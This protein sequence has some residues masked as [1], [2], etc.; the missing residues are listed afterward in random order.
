MVFTFAPVE[1]AVPEVVGLVVEGCV[2]SLKEG[3]EFSVL[4]VE[5]VT[6]QS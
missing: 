3:C 5:G 6:A 1:S 2:R 4:E